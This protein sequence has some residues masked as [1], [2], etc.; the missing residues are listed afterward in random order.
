MK[1]IIYIFM[2]TLLSCSCIKT[3]DLKF[4]DEPVIFVEAFP[5]I[6][7]VVVFTISPARS[8]SNSAEYPE[9]RPVITFKVNGEVIPVRLN[10]GELVANK[11]PEHCYI[12]DYKPVP[13]D[14]MTL[15]VSSE[16]FRSISA[17]TCIPEPF[18]ARKIDF[19]AIEVGELEFHVL[20]VS[21]DDAKESDSAYGMQIY[22]ECIYNFSDGTTDTYSYRYAGSDISDFYEMTPQSLE[23]IWLS[24]D[25]WYISGSHTGL[26]GW[27]DDSFNGATKTISRIV[28]T[29]TIGGISSTDSFYEHEIKGDRY[30][31]DGEITGSYTGISHNKLI[32]YT[33]SEEFYK[34]AVAHELMSENAG[35]F[36][37]LA[38]SNF[39]Y[40]NIIG[41]YGAFAGVTCVETD[42]ITPEFIENNR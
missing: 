22:E 12:A 38:P 14:R 26:A 16:G 21:F 5:G 33:M 2:V 1:K 34:Y 20:Y 6:E 37:G 23:G 17:S 32:L 13:G 7:D 18:P 39:C 30:N 25:G 40:T 4:D 3:F 19:R 8:Y 9:F 28:N 31:D 11:Y 36:A 24:F 10:E 27:D 41:G 15:E 35:M 42:W 29:Y